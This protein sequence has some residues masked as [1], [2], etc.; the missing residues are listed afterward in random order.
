MPT[1]F[2]LW[3]STAVEHSMPPFATS[4]RAFRLKSRD[5]LTKRS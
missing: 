2:F 4:G 5:C 1:P 3:W